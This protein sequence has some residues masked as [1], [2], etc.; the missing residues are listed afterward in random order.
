MVEFRGIIEV[1][2]Q[3]QEILSTPQLAI[4]N[5]FIQKVISERDQKFF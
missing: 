4:G 1:R 3:I 2:G 5:S